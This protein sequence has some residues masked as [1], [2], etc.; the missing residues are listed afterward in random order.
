MY[1][2]KR[3]KICLAAIMMGMTFTLCGCG[4]NTE[5]SESSSVVQDDEQYTIDYGDAESFEKALNEGKNLEG[6]IVRFTAGEIHP[7]SKLGYDVWA[8]EHLNF[9]S[10][11]NPDIQTDDVVTVRAVTIENL[12]G[13]WVINYEKVENASENENTVKNVITTN[14]KVIETKQ[15]TTKVTT[16]RTEPPK[17][18]TTTAASQN[19]YDNNEYYDI[20]ET[21]SYINSIGDT[22]IVHKVLGKQNVSVD[23]TMIAFASDGSVVGKSTDDITLTEGQ[24]NYFAYYFD[25]DVTGAELQPQAKAKS[26]NRRSDDNAVEMVQYNQSGNELYITFKQVSENL[27]SFA[28]FKLLFYSGDTIVKEDYGYFST[29]TENLCG[30][31]STDIASIWC[32]GLEFDRIEYI[33]EP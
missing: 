21:A 25:G 29:Y 6:K 22:I 24:Y 32:Y 3:I 33:F 14:A 1:K 20:V 26:S 27:G 13:S 10:T 28:K 9:V 19:T 4:N 11:R 23:A 2:L 18:E 17:T 30:I 12:L 15:T 8:G 5:S 31:D 7:D 16:K